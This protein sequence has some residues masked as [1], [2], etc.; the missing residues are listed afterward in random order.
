MISGRV[1]SLGVLPFI[2]RH[3]R[4]CGFHQ[5]LLAQSTGATQASPPPVRTTPAPT[6]AGG[7]PQNLSMRDHP[8]PYAGWHHW[9][10]MV[11]RSAIAI[12]FDNSPAY[13][14]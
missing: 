5:G 1:F 6:R 10:P 8:R 2:S 7:F 14:L 12:T 9:L 3:L 13:G 11:G 4:Y